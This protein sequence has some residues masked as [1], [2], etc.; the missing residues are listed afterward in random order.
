MKKAN[1]SFSIQRGFLRLWGIAAVKFLVVSCFLVTTNV[2]AQSDDDYDILLLTVPNIAAKVGGAAS[3]GTGTPPTT[4]QLTATES[5]L[6]FAH[7]QAR[8]SARLCGG[9]L[10]SAVPAL[11]WDARLAEAARIHS[12]DMNNTGVLNHR[13]SDNSTVG[14]RVT[15]QK[16]IWSTVGEN[17]ANGHNTVQSVVNA[18]LNST[19]H[20]NNI[21]DG[22]F[23]DIGA[24]RVGRFWTIVFA[25]LR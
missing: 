8:A 1:N 13:G 4:T 14:S 5:G 15:K 3:S 24:A 12:V 22:S 21:M 17:I 10:R 6:L 9:V 7:N 11:N 25:R 16:Y 20:C 18:F 23:R 2:G 19:G